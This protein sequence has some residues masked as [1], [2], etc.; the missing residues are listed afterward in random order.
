[1][2]ASYRKESNE[3]DSTLSSYFWESIFTSETDIPVR[4]VEVIQYSYDRDANELWALVRTSS[5]G[6]EDVLYQKH[7][8]NLA[9]EAEQKEV[10]EKIL[11]ELFDDSS[12]TQ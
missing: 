4:S 11:K 10:I 8:E 7:L 3:G 6:I 2:E 12:D 5:Q 1:M 9:D